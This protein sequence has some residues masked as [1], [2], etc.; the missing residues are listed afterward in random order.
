MLLH[1]PH[2]HLTP[3][4][5]LETIR[6]RPGWLATFHQKWLQ[7]L[8]VTS[9]PYSTCLEIL[10]LVVLASHQFLGMSNCRLEDE[11]SSSLLD[12]LDSSTGQPIPDCFGG[13]F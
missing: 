6:S 3:I 11:P 1:R 7:D 4:H 9:N 8:L 13:F 5:A 10:M 2:G 12:V